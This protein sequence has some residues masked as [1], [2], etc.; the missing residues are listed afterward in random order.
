M[1]K[2][3]KA[4]AVTVKKSVQF[5]F[6]KETPGAVC[7]EEVVPGNA[8]PGPDDKVIGTLYIRKAALGGVVPKSVSAEITFSA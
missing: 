5:N 1:S 7:F 4:A 3:A 6:K 2:G 8:N